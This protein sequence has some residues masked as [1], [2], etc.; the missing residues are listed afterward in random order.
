MHICVCVCVCVCVCIYIYMYVC[1]VVSVVSNSLQPHGLCICVYI[2]NI[3]IIHRHTHTQTDAHTYICAVPMQETQVRSL[4]EGMTTP[5]SIL[6]GKIP[7]TEEPGRL[8]SMGSQRV[9]HDLAPEHEH[10][11]IWLFSI[12]GQYKRGIFKV[13]LFF[14]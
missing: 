5:S 11:C 14:N 1:S 3:Y 8:Q 10:I 13:N 2:C 7:W 12:I 9:R 6:A 4:E